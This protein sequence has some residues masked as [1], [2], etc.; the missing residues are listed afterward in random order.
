MTFVF[1]FTLRE[2]N[3]KKNPKTHNTVL[4]GQTLLNTLLPVVGYFFIFCF[5]HVKKN[6]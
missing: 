2:K 1:F 5:H 3:I 6:A 4:V